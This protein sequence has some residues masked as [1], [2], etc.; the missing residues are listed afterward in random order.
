LLERPENF[1]RRRADGQVVVAG[2]DHDRRRFERKN[3]PVGVPN[4]VRQA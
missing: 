1:F 4:T 2:V 3:N